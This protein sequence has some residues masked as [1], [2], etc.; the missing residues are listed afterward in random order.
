MAL[1][2]TSCHPIGR[3]LLPRLSSGQEGLELSASR[4]G[5][6]LTKDYRQFS[7]RR[8][9]IGRFLDWPGASRCK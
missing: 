9:I 1:Q 3:G 2:S 5:G 7:P 6:D 4:A 8:L